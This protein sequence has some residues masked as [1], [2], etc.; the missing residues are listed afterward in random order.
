M[1]GMA[2]A[3]GTTTHIHEMVDFED[4]FSFDNYYDNFC[5]FTN[6]EAYPWTVV[7]DGNNHYMKSSN[8]GVSNSTSE[9]TMRVYYGVTG[10]FSFDAECRGEGTNTAWDKCIFYIDGT[11]QFCYGATITDQ[12]F[13]HYTYEITTTEHAP[14]FKWV[15]SKDNSVNPDGDYMAIDNIKVTFNIGIQDFED[16]P[17]HNGDIIYWHEF[18]NHGTYPWVLADVSSGCDN[19]SQYCVKSSNAGVAN[20]TSRLASRICLETDGYIHFQAKCMGEGTSTFWDHCDFKIDDEVVFTHGADTSGWHY[21]TFWITGGEHYLE[22]IYTKDSSV[23]P[24]GDCFLLDNISF[25]GDTPISQIH[26]EGFTEPVWGAHPD[27]ELTA[28]G[29]HYT[30]NGSSYWYYI[31]PATSDTNYMTSGDTFNNEDYIY[32]Q[33]I[34]VRP[35]GGYSF[36]DDVAIFINGSTDAVA[37]HTHLNLSGNIYDYV[38]TINYQVSNP[39][40]YISEVYINGFT[41]PE[42]GAQPDFDLTVPAGANYY[43]DYTNW[44]Y[45]DDEG[46]V[47]VTG[48]F[49]NPD[50]GYYQY[51][52]IKPNENCLFTD[53]VTIYVNNDPN[54]ISSHWIS[55]KASVY[56]LEAATKE[57]YVT[58]PSSCV[59]ITDINISY[60]TS[61]SV[62]LSWDGAAE[63]FTLKYRKHDLGGDWTVINNITENHYTLTGLQAETTYDVMVE[64]P[65]SEVEEMFTTLPDGVNDITEAGINVWN[66][67]GEIR[68]ELANDGHYTMNVVDILGQNILTSDISG[69]GSHIVRHSLT[70]GIYIV[71]LSNTDNNF[72][73]KIVVK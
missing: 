35:N 26:I 69:M 11:E 6:G 28:A 62:V 40:T 52:A 54:I 59:D 14:L 51:F 38:Y 21:Y 24:T 12:G 65:C 42:W 5:T 22:W 27:M 41:Q 66:H 49:N 43:I 34:C 63:S 44:Y 47:P 73:T 15:Y 53:D 2:N 56:V 39:D 57:Y 58:E 37:S 8:G 68:I 67:N 46:S 10:T 61:H 18:F 1:T 30:V 3:Q 55:S 9:I 50:V 17:D 7:A 25:H 16:G 64:S 70:A 23:N 13:I 45:N 36:P 71:T 33:I 60:F 31:N 48:T 32:Y 72:S 4:N 20:S 29:E 19:G